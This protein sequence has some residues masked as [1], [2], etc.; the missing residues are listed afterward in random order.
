MVRIIFPGNCYS[1]RKFIASVLLTDF[2][3]VD[4]ELHFDDHIS[5]I[6]IVLN[7]KCFKLNDK[8]FM[9]VARYGWLSTETMPDLTLNYLSLEE[10]PFKV[11]S[12]FKDLPVIYGDAFF[13]PENQILGI[14]IFGSAFFMLSRYEEAVLE[15][16]DVHG[17]FPYKS[18]TAYRSFGAM[19]PVVNELLELLWAMLHYYDPGLQRKK[20]DYKLNMS[21]DVDYIRDEAF[22]SKFGL[23]K[24]LGAD[25]IKRRSLSAVENTMRAYR[26]V[27]IDGVIANPFFT[28]GEMMDAWEQND[29]LG[30]F[31]FMFGHSH[32]YLD[33]EDY[34][35]NSPEVQ[36]LFEQIS[37]RNHTIG[38]HLA[39]HSMENDEWTQ[40]QLERF[41]KEFSNAPIHNR[42]HF[43]RFDIKK[44]PAQLE[45]MGVASD[46]SLG[47][48]EH[49]G[50]RSGTVF[51][52]RMYDLTERRALRIIQRPLMLMDV[53]LYGSNYMA[54][55]CSEA[56][57]KVKDILDMVKFYKGKFNGL[58]HNTELDEE[59]KRA[60][61]ESIISS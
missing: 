15:V 31:Y 27:K 34:A 6:E 46:S 61:F 50:F 36:T 30:T 35:V 3:G 51:D 33:G 13:D 2:L 18:S 24:R 44:T 21:C 5:H 47:Y 59:S 45:R 55:S 9:A 53:S 48:A 17:R 60:I 23:M 7:G 14:D 19:R 20:H 52:H 54:M 32:P 26:K 29:H 37:N 12:Y 42:Q 4:H 28:F 49:I 25:L 56:L 8:F 57:I 58:W 38:L 22:F 40:V 1:E 41:K 16:R 43:L 10:L 39:Y 11:N